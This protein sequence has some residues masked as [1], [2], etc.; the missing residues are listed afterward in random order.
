MEPV[1]E[2]SMVLRPPISAMHVGLDATPVYRK[3]SVLIGFNESTPLSAMTCAYSI[4]K[5]EK[6]GETIMCRFLFLEQLID[7]GLYTRA[8]R[9]NKGQKYDLI[10]NK[11]F[12]TDF[13]FS[14][15]LTQ[16]YMTAMGA[17]GWVVFCDDDTLWRQSP[18]RL[19]D[20]HA[21]P[22]YAVMVVKHN[23]NPM[24]AVKM[25]GKI[26]TNYDRKNWSSVM[27]WNLDH[28]S[29]VNLTADLVN[30]KP[31]AWLHGL[32]WLRDDEIGELPE[33]WNWLVGHSPDT[34]DPAVVHF[35]QGGPW[36]RP[37]RRVRY[38]DDWLDKAVELVN[39]GKP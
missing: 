33:K 10:D 13:S 17:S 27:L 19:L 26:Q 8:Y 36:L 4:K 11:P 21:D 6:P 18:F 24:Q 9:Y 34:I 3:M 31:G 29:N 30:T 22:K 5:N 39:A 12:S 2:P 20:E 38:A 1:V 7:R 32:R 23:H 16:V 14:R 35:T 28:P 25:D 37:Y 15:F